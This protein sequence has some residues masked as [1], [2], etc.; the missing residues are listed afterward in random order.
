MA[1]REDFGSVSSEVS[2]EC[3][4]ETL[5]G[6][7]RFINEVSQFVGSTASG[8]G[9]IAEPLPAPLDV[10]Q[11]LASGAPAAA[12]EAHCQQLTRSLQ[13]LG[14]QLLAT[15]LA[16]QQSSTSRN[17]TVNLV[18]EGLRMALFGM[19]ES[20][21]ADGGARMPGTTTNLSEATNTTVDEIRVRHPALWNAL[22]EVSVMAN[23][24]AAL[25]EHQQDRKAEHESVS[26]AETK[27]HFERLLAQQRR[28][29]QV[30]FDAE[31]ERLR[32]QVG[33]AQGAVIAR[34]QELA[35]LRRE[36]EEARR[37][38]MISPTGTGR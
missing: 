30:D 19:L 17:D 5:I 31:T 4:R 14:S 9:G 21:A 16:A 20:S 36:F 2:N 1:S 38:T 24:R 3:L 18:V 6:A 29:L 34:D 15:Q 33:E 11:V 8:I 13:A 35:W 26:E 25:I 32:K 27:R 7:A 28:A 22:Q 37:I 10:Q 23:E 12:V